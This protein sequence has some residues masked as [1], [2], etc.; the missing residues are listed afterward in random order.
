MGR[1]VLAEDYVRALRGKQVIAREVEQ[2][3]GGV[4]ALILPALA[5]RSAADWRGHGAGQRRP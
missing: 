3:L 1:H 4:D 2:A 5:D